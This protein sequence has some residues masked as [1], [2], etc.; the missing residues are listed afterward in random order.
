MAHVAS[1]SLVRQLGSLFEGGSAAGLS[2]RQLLERFTARGEPADEAA[3]AAIVARHGPMV[4]GVCRQ[5][6]GDH[7]HAE[8][9]FQATFFVL[10]RQARSIREPDRLG[11][12]LYG[13]AL[14]T[15]R[16]ARAQIDCR[17]RTEEESS[18]RQAV[19]CPSTA[20]RALIE[21]EQADA[22]HVEID[23]LPGAFRAPVVLCYFEGLTLDEAAH[24]LRWPVGTT[25]SRLARAREKLRR[26]L[27]R[28]GFAPSGAAIAAML[29]PRSAQASVSSLLCETTTRAAIPFA[30]R[31]AAIGRALSAPAAALAQEVLNTMFVQKL[32]AAALSVLLIATLATGAG[33][34]SINAFAHPR[35]AEPPG[36][37]DVQTARTEPRPP[38]SNRPPQGRMTVVGRVLD[39]EG[40]PMAGVPV[41]V[42]GQPRLPWVPTRPE[43]VDRVLIGQGETDADGRVRLDAVRTTST[44]FF[45][46][47]AV[48]AAPGF[49]LG[50]AQLNPDAEQPAAEI[51]LQPEQA[52][53][54]KLVDIQGRPA[55][56][57]TIAVHAAIRDNMYITFDGIILGDCESP[58]KLR[59]WPRPVTTDAQGRFTINGIGRGLTVTCRM[60]DPRYPSE[61][62]R[63]P[64]DAKE[65]PKEIAL[66]LT[67][68]IVVE[69]RVLADDTGQPIARAIVNQVRAD[70]RG[71]F[72]IHQQFNLVRRLLAVPPEGIAYLLGEDEFKLP[73]GAVKVAHDI[74]LRRG[75]IIRGKV[76]EDKTGRPIAGAT[77]QYLAARKS[78][79]IID[80]WQAIVATGDDGSYQIAVV[81]GQGHLFVYGPTPD[82]VLEVIGSRTLDRN[83]QPGGQRYYAHKIIPYD[84]KLGDR[85]EGVDATL[86]PG[87]TVKGRVVGPE[88]QAV[89]D[90]RIIATLHFNYTHLFWRGDLGPQAHD[91][92]FELHGLDPERPVRVSFLDPDHGWGTAMDLSGKQAGEEVTIRLQPCGRARAR[93]VDPDGKPI[94]ETFPQF[95]IVGSPGPRLDTR[96]QREQAELAA[97]TIY[98]P[99]VDPRYHRNLPRTD[100]DGRITFPG[101]IP[102][103]RYRISGSYL[104]APTKIDPTYRD[105]TVKPGETID[106]GEITIEKSS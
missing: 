7:H 87:R 24:R 70:D 32:K 31:R 61:W 98:M 69:G 105:F 33:Y 55:A 17:R 21:R 94:A 26:G 9:A 15:A 35:E 42:V 80:G 18:A 90:A 81:P 20:D 68:G 14:R 60:D 74:R 56:G 97:D 72:T 82:Y 101:L 89:A 13:V 6:L 39:P 54:G 37:P 59:S 10:A 96:N 38:D 77:V 103:T 36:E 47:D 58:E 104:Y 106:L 100:A 51:R 71:H 78:D 44:R 19:E 41:D 49:G 57:V 66:A 75:V 76:T 92:R 84:A 27:L 52:I 64:T 91:G 34:L 4:L 3:F 46:V 86:R 50:W 88:G 48:A 63:I 79:D 1:T 45:G 28:R 102:G 65:G 62:F 11:N 93:L 99:A 85:L 23:R 67:P 12:W 29:P 25:R 16:Q 5:L 43:R 53:R 2:D 30:A 8:D 73:K 95:E 22:L 83:P 40:R